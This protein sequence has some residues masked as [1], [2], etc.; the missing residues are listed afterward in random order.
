MI[1][2][3]LGQIPVNETKRFDLE[4][5]FCEMGG[6]SRNIYSD[7]VFYRQALKNQDCALALITPENTEQIALGQILDV[8]SMDPNQPKSAI[9]G[10][11]LDPR[12]V[13]FDQGIAVCACV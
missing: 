11:V 6:V 12:D 10:Y 9:M 13:A 4:Q 8:D 7:I 5:W 2:W 3:I 1:K